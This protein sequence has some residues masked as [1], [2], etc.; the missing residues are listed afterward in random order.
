MVAAGVSIA[1]PSAGES[2]ELVED[3]THR[4]IPRGNGVWTEARWFLFRRG[5]I[6][7]EEQPSL[8]GYQNK[9]QEWRGAGGGGIRGNVWEVGI[10]VVV[11]FFT[12]HEA[13]IYHLND[14]L[15]QG[16]RLKGTVPC[17]WIQRPRP[18][19]G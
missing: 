14:R 5:E 6:K 17:H 1:L 16:Q 19:T 7:G 2:P 11:A 3:K 15:S 13:E 4:R 9:V 12:P 10:V 8:D 18:Q